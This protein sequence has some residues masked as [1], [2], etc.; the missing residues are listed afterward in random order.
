[1]N[2]KNPT[3]KQLLNRLQKSA[4]FAPPT[5][6]EADELMSASEEAHIEDARL[7]EIADAV[8]R[9]ITP[10]HSQDQKE[11]WSK[12][13]TLT[14]ADRKQFV[15]NRNKGKVD[16][17]IMKQIEEAEQKALGDNDKDND[18]DGLDS[19]ANMP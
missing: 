18:K 14:E 3:L 8:V 9:G 6:E 12:E 1:M 2:N 5:P 17:D 4:G 10:E 11:L 15:L 19:Q 7:L 13:T 16:E